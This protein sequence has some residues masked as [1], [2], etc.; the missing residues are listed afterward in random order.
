MPLLAIP[1][2]RLP[3][4]STDLPR[5]GNVEGQHTGD[6]AEYD[7]PLDR[8][9]ARVFELQGRGQRARGDVPAAAHTDPA[10]AE[11]ERRCEPAPERSKAGPRRSAGPTRL[12]SS[13]A[14]RDYARK[15]SA[16]ILRRA[17]DASANGGRLSD[18][19]IGHCDCRAPIAPDVAGA[20]E[21]TG[22]RRGANSQI[23]WHAC[24][25]GARPNRC[26]Q[27]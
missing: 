17:S 12:G 9:L 4:E 26:L 8:D 10:G 19:T 11:G 2:L 13:T 7:G 22:Q 27:R 21:S 20:S 16:R 23:C 24:C 18:D 6:A 15:R 14:K 5:C 1:R 25:L 3:G